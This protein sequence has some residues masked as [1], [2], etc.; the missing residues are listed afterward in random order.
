M[1]ISWAWHACC[2]RSAQPA[3][4]Q[5][6]VCDICN[7]QTSGKGFKASRSIP[8]CHFSALSPRVFSLVLSQFCFRSWLL[9]ADWLAHLLVDKVPEWGQ[10]AHA[11]TPERGS[12]WDHMQ[13][14]TC[15]LRHLTH[16][17]M[18]TCM[19]AHT[20]THKWIHTHTHIQ[21][22]GGADAYTN[23]H[24]ST[25]FQSPPASCLPTPHLINP[26]VSLTKQERALSSLWTLKPVA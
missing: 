10:H 1:N 24:T 8:Q 18:H 6:W 20:Q 15:T 11:Y 9:S 7:T 26:C 17:K 5:Y 4:L 25:H 22:E 13:T 16:N 3:W 21:K 23:T 14:Q 2:W 19:H 12:T